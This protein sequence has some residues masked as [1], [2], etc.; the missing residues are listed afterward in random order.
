VIAAEARLPPVAFHAYEATEI[1]RREQNC[2]ATSCR[3]RIALLGEGRPAGY[4]ARTPSS[5][6]GDLV[7]VRMEQDKPTLVEAII[8]SLLN[9]PQ[10]TP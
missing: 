1:M 5:P 7:I 6:Y 4:S 2:S 9:R 3:S 10:D 8:N